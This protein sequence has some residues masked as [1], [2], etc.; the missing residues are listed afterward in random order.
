[1]G[2]KGSYS[3]L[4]CQAADNKVPFDVHLTYY[5]Q[6][7]TG[8]LPRWLGADGNITYATRIPH[9]IVE[10]TETGGF[11]FQETHTLY[12]TVNSGG[13]VLL[14]SS[15]EG[16][17]TRVR[18]G[19]GQ[20]T[21]RCVPEDSQ[22]VYVQQQTQKEIVAGSIIGSAMVLVVVVFVVGFVVVWRRKVKREEKA[23]NV[24][25]FREVGS[26]EEGRIA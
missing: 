1:V 4:H 17:A 25:Q 3:I 15:F 19:V 18:V 12:S 5:G 10:T 8:H 22:E 26:G 14:T 23:D 24:I 16:G 6:T 7:S 21:Q 9:L 11:T 20:E 13:V 2:P